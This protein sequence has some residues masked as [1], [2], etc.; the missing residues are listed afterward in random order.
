MITS[1][2]FPHFHM[3]IKVNNGFVAAH[4]QCMPYREP[5][6]LTIHKLKKCLIHSPE[7]LPF[8]V[9]FLCDLLTS[10]PH[11]KPVSNVP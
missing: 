9:N 2:T 1:C 10:F 8:S 11:S 6:E 5:V 7:L 4:F 3:I